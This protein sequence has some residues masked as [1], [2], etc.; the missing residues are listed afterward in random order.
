MALHD[1]LTSHQLEGLEL[2]QLG[3]PPPVLQAPA[4][5]SPALPKVLRMLSRDI[6]YPA[7]SDPAGLG[8]SNK[9]FPHP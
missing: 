9:S 5:P 6:V 7:D 3:T 1:M 8:L 2:G 4:Q